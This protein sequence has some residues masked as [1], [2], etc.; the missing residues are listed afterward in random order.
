VAG[1]LFSCLVKRGWQWRIFGSAVWSHEVSGGSSAQL[2]RYWRMAVAYHTHLFD[3]TRITVSDAQHCFV[4]H[5]TFQ[6][7][8]QGLRSSET[9]RGVDWLS[10]FGT[11][12]LS[13]FQGLLTAC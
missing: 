7:H 2:F 8:S 9:L 11:A 12:C 10:T 4:L 1:V 5:P 13:D 3:Y 6:T